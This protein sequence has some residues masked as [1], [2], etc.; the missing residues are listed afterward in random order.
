[1][2]VLQGSLEQIKNLIPFLIREIGSIFGHKLNLGWK[3]V[4]SLGYACISG[5]G[6][7]TL[8]SFPKHDFWRANIKGQGL[9]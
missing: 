4:I 8:E 1:M 9:M 2:L 6:R 7:F 3:L 5:K